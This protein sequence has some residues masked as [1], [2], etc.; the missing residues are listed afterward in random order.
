MV[1]G[2]D[3]TVS[4]IIYFCFQN[5]WLQTDQYTHTM[6][7]IGQDHSLGLWGRVEGSN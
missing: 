1:K 7:P 6:C 3:V 2:E 5:H 4:L